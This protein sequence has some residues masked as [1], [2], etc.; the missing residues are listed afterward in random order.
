MYQPLGSKLLQ[1]GGFPA[2]VRPSTSSPKYSPIKSNGPTLSQASALQ[3]G[4]SSAPSNTNGDN[5]PSAFTFRFNDCEMFVPA[6]SRLFSTSPPSFK[7]ASCP[8]I[9]PLNGISSTRAT[10]MKLL[11]SLSVVLRP[12]PLKTPK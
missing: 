8:K 12:L 5:E 2:T 10:V 6:S 11:L 9:C 1:P 4:R 3:A 7:L